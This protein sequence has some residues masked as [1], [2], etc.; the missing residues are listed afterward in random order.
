MNMNLRLTA[1]ILLTCALHVPALQAQPRSCRTSSVAA[2][3]LTDVVRSLAVAHAGAV[4]IDTAQSGRTPITIGQALIYAARRHA[5][6]II[7][8]RAIIADWVTQPDSNISLSAR[9]FVAAYDALEEVANQ[10]VT[11]VRDVLNGDMAEGA[12]NRA[13][14]LAQLQLRRKQA[15]DALLMGSAAAS[16]ALVARD[17]ATGRARYL[18]ISAAER[19]AIVVMIHDRFG[20][21]LKPNK[22]YFTSDYAAAA[23]MLSTFVENPRWQVLP[24]RRDEQTR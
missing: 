9:L 1:A 7:D 6:S 23:S 12:G 15:S 18:R 24:V 4:D 22:D 21:S 20:A 3:Y 19:R 11:G 17:S 14:H 13:D 2:C 10:T 5:A 8:A 16:H